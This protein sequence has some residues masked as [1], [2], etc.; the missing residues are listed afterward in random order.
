MRLELSG[1]IPIELSGG[2]FMTVAEFYEN[3]T[4]YGFGMRFL[5]YEEDGQVVKLYGRA[6]P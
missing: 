2:E 3:K 6:T 1:D 5:V 4:I